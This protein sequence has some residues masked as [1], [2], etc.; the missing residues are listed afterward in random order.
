MGAWTKLWASA[1]VLSSLACTRSPAV[2]ALGSSAERV[3]AGGAESASGGPHLP[4]LRCPFG[5]PITSAN[6]FPR[7]Q[8]IR[9]SGDT[10][11]V[12][13]PLSSRPLVFRR[14]D[15]AW[16]GAGVLLA[17]IDDPIAGSPPFAISDTTA[18]VAFARLLQ[19]ELWTYERDGDEWKPGQLVTTGSYTFTNFGIAGDSLLVRRVD[20]VVAYA[21][22][23][24][25]WVEKQPVFA[26]DS[27]GPFGEVL[28]L[29]EDTAFILDGTSAYVFGL[30]DGTWS[31]I[32]KLLPSEGYHFSAVRLDGDTALLASEAGIQA[33]RR[34]AASWSLEA[35]VSSRLAPFDLHGDMAI[36]AMT[37]YRRAGG[38]WPVWSDLFVDGTPAWSTTDVSEVRLTDNGALVS[39]PHGDYYKDG[40]K[41]DGY[42][43]LV[44]FDGI[45]EPEHCEEDADCRSQ[46][47]VE[48][49]CCQSA[50]SGPCQSCL[51]KYTGEPFD[52][53][54]KNLAAGT[55]PLN[56]CD[57]QAPSTCGT[58]GVCD[59]AGACELFP[60]GTACDGGSV[61]GAGVCQ[62]SC[63][64]DRECNRAAG[65]A[66]VSGVCRA[67]QSDFGAAGA[68]SG[69]GG[70]PGAAGERSESSAAAGISASPQGGASE[71]AEAGRDDGS[72][73]E[74]PSLNG[75]HPA[76][77]GCGVRGTT[78]TSSGPV[79]FMLL[80]GWLCAQRRRRRSMRF[81]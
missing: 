69:E 40:L 22:V 73:S 11:L 71:T 23:G 68:A 62:T 63:R 49:T 15:G 34:T 13:S 74:A 72:K 4:V 7:F 14:V 21:R 60:A 1:L 27:E 48:G 6:D 3:G 42:T 70:A 79:P 12:E 61:C 45:E 38:T 76:G 44:G 54:C 80:L 57:A 33:F 26:S 65:Y 41:F 9:A 8:E 75:A 64:T 31:E 47:C 58:T 56:G 52:G 32:Q 77:G 78:S 16:Q 43:E 29:T 18:A 50:C 10:A 19:H 81:Q 2:D 17:D 67:P 28:A 39:I 25:S 24:G 36:V 59:G 30:V 55:D 66:C 51:G 37:V 46:H 5:K 20:A 53:E 35:T